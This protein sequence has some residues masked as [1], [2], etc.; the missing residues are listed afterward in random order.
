M[1]SG[2]L[3][4]IEGIEG[5]GK[6][7]L[8]QGLQQLLSANH[9]VLLTRE[10]GG[11]EV[12]ERIRDILKDQNSQIDAMSEL[13]LMFASR[14]LHVQQTIIP[15]IKDGTIVISD[16]YLDASYAYQGGG[17]ELEVDKIAI[18]DQW[19]CQN[20]QPDIVIL[21]TCK[22]EVA[23][24]RVAKRQNYLDRFEQEALDFFIR[25]QDSYKRSV[26]MRKKHLIIDAEQSA[27]QVLKLAYEFIK[28]VL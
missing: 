17:R 1:Y 11:S 3:I 22:P 6:S 19:I 27:E 16:R 14:S 26:Q 8:A 20:A 25:A 5:T 12:A 13:L 24:Q 28:T 9:E 10:P 4:A 23:M 21:L 7:T 18:L 15:N 2:K